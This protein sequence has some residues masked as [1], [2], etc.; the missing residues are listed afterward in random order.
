MSCAE[1]YQTVSFEAADQR[2]IALTMQ[3]SLL[4]PII[5][6][7]RNLPSHGNRLDWGGSGEAVIDSQIMTLHATG[8]AFIRAHSPFIVGIRTP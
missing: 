2:G 7:H 6:N 1:G 3:T 5:A 4:S 8:R